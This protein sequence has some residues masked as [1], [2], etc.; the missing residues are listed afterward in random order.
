ME[1]VIFAKDLVKDIHAFALAGEERNGLLTP[2]AH[3]PYARTTTFDRTPPGKRTPSVPDSLEMSG[4]ERR[5]GSKFVEKSPVPLPSGISGGQAKDWSDDELKSNQRK[6]SSYSRTLMVSDEDIYGPKETRSSPGSSKHYGG[7]VKVRQ[8]LAKAEEGLS[9]VAAAQNG[10]RV[11]PRI[12]DE[13]D[14]AMLGTE[15]QGG[16]ASELPSMSGPTP[17]NDMFTPW[18]MDSDKD[19]PSGAPFDATPPRY[20]RFEADTVR[21]KMTPKFDALSYQNGGQGLGALISK[22]A[23]LT[24]ALGGATA[25]AVALSVVLGAKTQS[26]NSTRKSKLKKKGSRNSSVTKS[27]KPQRFRG[28]ADV[29]TR[30]SSVL[31]EPFFEETS[32]S[33][34]DTDSYTNEQAPVMNVHRPPSSRSFPSNPPPDVKAAMG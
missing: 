11:A 30:A 34:M 7:T 20:S 16:A 3:S 9:E 29:P 24:V 14:T 17:V 5:G 1:K 25:A 32:S 6:Y 22:L 15:W 13:E 26:N 31:E 18:S 10:R 4:A 28:E 12:L 33:W 8:L 19:S 27:N 23:G 2:G 21:T